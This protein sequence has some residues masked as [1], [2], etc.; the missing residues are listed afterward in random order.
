MGTDTIKDFSHAE[1]DKLDLSDLLPSD[2]ETNLANYLKLSTDTAGN[3]TLQI[4]TKGGMT[5]AAATV[6]PDVTSRST[7]R[8]G[9]AVPMPSSR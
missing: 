6:T 7:M 5:S 8:T 2:A 1:G 9:A 3:S 4:S